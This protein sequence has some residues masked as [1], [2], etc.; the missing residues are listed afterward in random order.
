ME[1]VQKCFISF[2]KIRSSTFWG[3]M[4]SR[5]VAKFGKS[6]P[7]GSCC[8]VDWFGGQK[9]QLCRTPSSCSFCLTKLICTQNSMNVVYP[10]HV[11]LHRRPIW[12]GLV[13]FCRNSSQK[14]DHSD[15]Q[16]DYSNTV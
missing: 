15:P 14:I 1:S 16:S 2:Q 7:L 13:G 6:Q 12:S 8:T 4:D 10:W 5:V 11:H 9:P 3:D